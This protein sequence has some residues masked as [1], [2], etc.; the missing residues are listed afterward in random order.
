MLVAF[1][2]FGS[3]HPSECEVVAHRGFDG[4]FPND[5]SFHVLI[6][7]L[8]IFFGEMSTQVLCPFLSFVKF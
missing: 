4:H 2:F 6:G 3:S 7:H 1:C 8:H 5:A